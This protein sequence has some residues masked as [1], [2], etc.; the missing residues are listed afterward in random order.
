MLLE[1]SRV[2]QPYDAVLGAIRDGYSVPEAAEAYGVSRQSVHS[3]LARYE[4]GGLPALANRS[5]R[6]RSS[7]LPMPADVEARVLELRRLHTASMSPTPS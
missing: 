1:L 6:P 2:Q 7:P 4:K 3:R 5:H